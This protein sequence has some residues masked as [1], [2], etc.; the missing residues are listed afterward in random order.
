MTKQEWHPDTLVSVE[1]AKA[2]IEEQFSELHPVTSIKVI[3]EGWDNKVFLVN[4]EFIFRFPHRHISVQL[5]ERENHILEALQS[6]VTLNIP[7][8][9]YHGQPTNIFPYPYHGYR[10]LHGVSGC[11]A[12]LNHQERIDNIKPFAIFL[13]ELHSIH[14]KEAIALGAQPQ[15]FDRTSLSRIISGSLDRI[16]KLNQSKIINI[17]KSCFNDEIN[18]VQLAQLPEDK[19]LVHGDLYCRHLFFENKSLTG[20]ID[21]GDTGINSPAVDLAALFSFFPTECHPA[22]FEIY[23]EVTP[24]T[25]TFARFIAIHSSIAILIY[26]HD[27]GD[28][29]LYTEALANL[30]RIN[31]HLLQE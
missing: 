20:I 28:K 31:P 19:V 27:V 23:G 3:G 22:F 25:L 13:K 17:S 10:Q 2:C 15:V 11:Y 24:G 30:N 16:D 7:N 9:V 18:Q 14:E 21:W 12:K 1:I 26:A 6:R 29:L 4:D 5:I 8:P